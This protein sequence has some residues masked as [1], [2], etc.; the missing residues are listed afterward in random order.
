MNAKKQ[1]TCCGVSVIAVACLALYCSGCSTEV[2]AAKEPPHLSVSNPLRRDAEIAE[3]YVGQIRSIRHIDLRA[4]AHGYLEKIFV[5]EGQPVKEGQLMFELMS[6]VYQAKVGR[7]Q[8]EAQFA[9]VEY[10]NTERL[11]KTNVVAASELALSRAKLDKA[12]AELTL[13]RVD[14][15]FTQVKAPFDGIMGKFHSR[16]GSLIET[17][18]LLTTLSD[19]REMW[20]YFNVPEGV[21]LKH[22]RRELDK[23]QMQVKLVMADGTIYSHPGK[24]TSIEADFNNETGTIGYRATFPNPEGLLRHGQTG[25]VLLDD[26]I[27]NALLIPQSA[28][29]EILDKRFVFT[30]DDSNKVTSKEIKVSA[31]MP[32]LLVVSD[33][34]GDK[35]K[36]LLEGQRKVNEGDL[37]VPQFKDP[38]EVAASL[39]VYAE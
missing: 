22:K 16:P 25:K 9:E 4:L 32:D 11:A 15:A 23:D 5:D 6:S 36:I 7:A 31:Q 38:A 19:N 27:K 20:V 1:L 35:D 18:E 34:L 21:Y 39:K 8:A 3:E 37:I 26:T 2:E 30:L 10:Q 24:V 28:V 17:G 29:F 13:D 33:G 14:L 12:K